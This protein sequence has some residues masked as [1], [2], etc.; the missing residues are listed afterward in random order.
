MEG[1][2]TNL[3]N[4][5]MAILSLFAAFGLEVTPEQRVAILTAIS[6]VVWPLAMLVMRYFTRGPMKIPGKGTVRS[7]WWVVVLLLP[8]LWMSGCQTGD[9][10]RDLIVEF[11]AQTAVYQ[12]VD[13][14]VADDQARAMRIQ[15]VAATLIATLDGD[16]EATVAELQALAER[17]IDW[18]RLSPIDRENLRG[19]IRLTAAYLQSYIEDG[20]LP[21]DYQVVI[22]QVLVWFHTAAGLAQQ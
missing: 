5:A 19:L 16:A 8:L 21:E 12:G 10:Q 7:P 20:Q 1:H 22:R 18:D 4:G 15:E 6:T 13:E 2:K 9:P 11:T 3:T 14:F 17:E